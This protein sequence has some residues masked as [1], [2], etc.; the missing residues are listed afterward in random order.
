[1]SI[2]GQEPKK[3][4]DFERDILGVQVV[5]PYKHEGRWVF[6]DQEGLRRDIAPA[7]A[8]AVSLSPIV[9]GADRLIVEGTK[10]KGIE[11]PE[12][13]FRLLFSDKVFPGADVEFR[14]VRECYDGHVYNVLPC[15]DKITIPP[16]QQAWICPY[17]MLYYP[18]PPKVLFLR[19]EADSDRS[20][21]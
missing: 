20:K 10:R 21:D 8:T 11:N 5:R 13:G 18:T 7:G 15:G 3:D 9:V 12:K 19:I 16:D 17:L 14:W 4:F 6:D 2:F 1:M